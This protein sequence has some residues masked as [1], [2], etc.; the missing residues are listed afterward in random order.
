M[1]WVF[2]GMSN[3]YVTFIRTTVFH[4]NSAEG[5]WH[6]ILRITLAVDTS[7]LLLSSP[8]IQNSINVANY[9]LWMTV[10]GREQNIHECS[11]AAFYTRMCPAEYCCFLELQPLSLHQCFWMF[12]ARLFVNSSTGGCLW[13]APSVFRGNTSSASSLWLPPHPDSK[14]NKPGLHHSDCTPARFFAGREGE[15]CCSGPW[16][17]QICWAGRACVV[18]LSFYSIWIWM[19]G[20]EAHSSVHCKSHYL[21]LQRPPTPPPLPPFTL[22]AGPLA[23]ADETTDGNTCGDWTYFM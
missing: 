5:K 18:F 7:F 20:G 1:G 17:L 6:Q 16:W 14:E 9:W 3:W 21:L 13:E 11:V 12:H 8:F 15:R 4:R 19:T 22:P 2:A 10:S 23:P